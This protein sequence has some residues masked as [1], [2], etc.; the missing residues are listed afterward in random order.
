M[1]EISSSSNLIGTYVSI[2]PDTTETELSDTLAWA[3]KSAA[4]RKRN[5]K[6]YSVSLKEK[7]KTI[8]CGINRPKREINTVSETIERGRATLTEAEEHVRRYES[9]LEDDFQ[10]DPSP[11]NI[12]R[13]L[14]NSAKKPK[15]PTHSNKKMCDSS[16]CSPMPSL[17]SQPITEHSLDVALKS[18]T[19]KET[20]SSEIEK[21]LES[22]NKD[23]VIPQ[24]YNKQ[25]LFHKQ[26]MLRKLQNLD[27]MQESE[28]IVT[29]P[30]LTENF[31]PLKFAAAQRSNAKAEK[32]AEATINADADAMKMTIFKARPLPGGTIIKN[33]PYALTKS[34][35]IKRNLTIN[36]K[37]E[38]TKDRSNSSL[39][40]SITLQEKKPF[41]ESSR[42]KQIYH[43][44]TKTVMQEL[45]MKSVE[46]DSSSEDE[47]DLS[48]L[49]QNIA[50]LK[51][52]LKLK[53]NQCIKTIGLIDDGSPSGNDI[54]S[55][56]DIKEQIQD[57]NDKHNRLV[58]GDDESQCTNSLYIRHQNW[59]EM[60]QKRRI[61]TKALHEEEQQIHLTGMPDIAIAKKSWSKA[62]SE[63]LES[64]EK[65]LIKEK[66]YKDEKE[67]KD[68]IFE[69]MNKREL[70]A[71]Q[72][73][74]KRK[75][76]CVE[77]STRKRQVNIIDSKIRTNE[78]GNTGGDLLKRVEYKEND[79]KVKNKAKKINF[80]DKESL[81]F[82]SYII[83]SSMEKNDVDNKERAYTLSPLKESD[84]V[85]FSKIEPG[86][87]CLADLD[88]REFSKLVNE[89]SIKSRKSGQKKFDEEIKRKSIHSKCVKNLNKQVQQNVAH[90]SLP[91]KIG[92][93]QQSKDHLITNRMNVY[94]SQK[95]SKSGR[96]VSGLAQAKLMAELNLPDLY[97][98]SVATAASALVAV[99]EEFN[100]IDGG[101]TVQKNYNENLDKLHSK[102][103]PYEK[104]EKGSV[105]FFDKSSSAEMGRFRVRDARDFSPESMKRKPVSGEG[106]T[107]GVLLLVGRNNNEIPEKTDE[108]AITILFDKTKFSEKTASD[109]WY[110]HRQLFV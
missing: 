27:F 96:F 69:E 82:D 28:K 24:Q 30:K 62:K 59:L 106:A 17:L 66:K 22:I 34:A 88:D 26:F 63:H 43:A 54:F 41:Q 99:E 51:A 39:N 45:V 1:N 35:S 71:I 29:Q 14:K 93:K 9:C 65:A 104:F 42:R 50:K 52:D 20:K 58:P 87:C 89:L 60:C 61:S 4:K 19:T 94:K 67:K 36:R 10:S 15:S 76:R 75:R 25:L 108:L 37:G 21:I 109:W 2:F 33:D 48:N 68:K 101:A 38:T 13:S 8:Q 85:S 55:H 107:D 31:D 103:I 90:V 46:E 80:I 23:T 3:R 12:T 102:Q 56:L 6:E 105:P 64:M 78:S 11:L 53:C 79:E 92:K 84:D 81:P 47:T 73:Q 57:N 40:G 74:V 97:E 44:I 70:D 32:V 83:N 100:Q 16:S 86:I 98:S 95:V 5:Y 77:K 91:I 49:R 18:S 110:Q 7:S 72:M